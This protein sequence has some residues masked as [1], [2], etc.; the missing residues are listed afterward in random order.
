MKP[1]G[2]AEAGAM[3]A[4]VPGWEMKDQKLERTFRFKDYDATTAFVAKV[5]ALAKAED[6]HPEVTFGY[7]TC[8]VVWWT[9]AAGGLTENDFICAAKVGDLAV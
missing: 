3:L 5:A 9:H 8:R 7:R 6:H 2:E 1:Y 4:V